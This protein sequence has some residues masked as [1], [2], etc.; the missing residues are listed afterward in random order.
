MKPPVYPAILHPDKEWDGYWVEFPDLP[1]CVTQGKALEEAFLM[2]GDALD[3]WLC[4]AK[5]LPKPTPLQKIEA[6]EGAFV[7]LVQPVTYKS[8][9]T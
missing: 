5:E 2:A 8:E 6:E 7:L 1:G 4:Y 3:C 9:D